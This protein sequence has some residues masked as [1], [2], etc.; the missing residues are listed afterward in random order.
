MLLDILGYFSMGLIGWF[1]LILWR[2][3]ATESEVHDHREGRVYSHGAPSPGTP[4]LVAVAPYEARRLR[5]A[6]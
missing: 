2:H 5:R 3:S 1:L 4:I 6:R